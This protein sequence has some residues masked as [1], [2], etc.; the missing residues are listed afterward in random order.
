MLLRD[1]QYLLGHVYG[2]DLPSDVRDFLVTDP[3]VIRELQGN[4]KA[5]ETEEKL[6]IC[7]DNDE[8]GVTLYID[9][10][11]LKRLSAYDPRQNLNGDNL[12]DF[13]IALEGVSHF[14][15]IIWNAAAEKCVTLLEMEMQA[16]V[17]KYVGARVLLQA[18][19]DGD[20]STSLHSTL[21]DN[22]RFHDQMKSDELQ[23]YKSASELAGRYCRTLELRYAQDRV[24]RHMT[25]DL[26]TFFRLP[27]PAKL[28]HINAASFL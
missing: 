18:Q 14:N 28:S 10:E 7:Q 1:L 20:F 2:I 12:A 25:R 19:S 8:L 23:R 17:D 3:V 27:Q 5:R 4:A 6:L 9:E 21:F 24:C 22:P 26:R 11:L 13:C 16:E 15:Y